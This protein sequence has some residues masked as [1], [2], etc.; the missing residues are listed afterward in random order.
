MDALSSMWE[1]IPHFGLLLARVVGFSTGLP[2]LG[3]RAVPPTVRALL[4]VSLTWALLPLVEAP[5]AQDLL[6]PAKWGLA[7]LQ[8]ALLGLCVG[9]LAQLVLG[10]VPLAAQ[11]LGYQMGLG[12]ANVM[13]PV[14]QQ[15]MSVAAQFMQLFALWL[16][17]ALDGH[18]LAL[19]ALV[20]GLGRYPLGEGL[21]GLGGSV[22]MGRQLFGSA[23]SLVAPGILILLFVQVGLGVLARMVPQMNI[24]IV[25]APFQIGM[26]LVAMGLVVGI[27]GAG[28]PSCLSWLGEAYRSFLPEA[29]LRMTG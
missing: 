16:F 3:A 1:R 9:W 19:H 28:I 15:Q 25:A 20:G 17:L 14:G 27:L 26:G 8:E 21:M 24:F 6:D 4:V 18:H 13:D 5:P 7:A 29:H 11:V 2:V 12:I 22:E 23:L 10:A